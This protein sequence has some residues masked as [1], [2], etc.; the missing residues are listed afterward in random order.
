MKKIYNIVPKQGSEN[1]EISLI[2]YNGKCFGEWN[3]NSNIDY[4]EDLTLCR[5][6]AELIDIGIEIGKTINQAP[7]GE[8]K[9]G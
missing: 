2:I 1:E 9:E 6:L 7:T 8:K 4:P 3:D 5:E